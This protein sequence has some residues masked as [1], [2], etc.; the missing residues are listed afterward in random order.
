MKKGAYKQLNLTHLEAA[1]PHVLDAARREQWTYETL[2]ERALAAELDGREQKAIARRLKAARMPGKKTL[3]GFDFTFQPTLSERRLRELADLSFVRTCT[4]VVFLGPPGTGKTHL[5][6]AL[7][8]RALTAGHSVLFT[9][10]AELP[11][12]LGG[13]LHPGLP[14]PRPR[15]YIPP[16]LLV[17][18][19]QRYTHLSHSP[20]HPS[21]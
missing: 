6:L 4:N 19:Q 20:A 10:L 17:T 16:S 21:F 8:E 3:D 7:A 9:T 15:P 14:R 1:L 5:S 2:L 13:A 11:Q 18:H 12:A